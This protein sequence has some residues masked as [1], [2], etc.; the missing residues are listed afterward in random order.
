LELSRQRL[1][2]VLFD[3]PFTIKQLEEEINKAKLGGEAGLQNDMEKQYLKKFIKDHKVN[4]ENIEQ[5]N[6]NSREA[7][8]MI[9]L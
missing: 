1:E 6:K 2:W 4:H 7:R 9:D 3:T 8:A 5:D